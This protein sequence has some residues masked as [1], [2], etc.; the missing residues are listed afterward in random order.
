MQQNITDLRKQLRKKEN[1]ESQTMGSKLYSEIQ[2]LEKLK[3][4]YKSSIVPIQF[5]NGV[6]VDGSLI[7]KYIKR[8][9]QLRKLEINDEEGTDLVTI[10]HIAL[11]SKGTLTLVDQSKHY[12]R[13]KITNAADYIEEDNIRNYRRDKK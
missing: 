10:K 7:K 5:E 3:K 6:V 4:K 2:R 11:E 12:E 9:K 8:I 1:K 13:M